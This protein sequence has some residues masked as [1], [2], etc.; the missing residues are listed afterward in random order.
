M[1]LLSSFCSTQ[2]NTEQSTTET[3]LTYNTEFRY[4]FTCTSGNTYDMT[5]PYTTVTSFLSPWTYRKSKVFQLMKLG[6]IPSLHFRVLSSASRAAPTQGAISGDVTPNSI[7][8][9]GGYRGHWLGSDLDPVSHVSWLF[10]TCISLR[11]SR[12]PHPPSHVFHHW[13]QI[14]E[15][16][17][18]LDVGKV[19]INHAA[20][21]TVV[22]VHQYPS[23]LRN[24]PE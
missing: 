13:S 8:L 10:L 18:K 2:L 16:R 14:P 21:E 1:C 3:M 11:P 15:S 12:D 9:I 19:Y 6:S 22:T 20:L 5:G 17:V 24:S 23:W 7:L 4:A